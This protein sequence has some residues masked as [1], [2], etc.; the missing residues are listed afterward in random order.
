MKAL[1]KDANAF[2]ETLAAHRLLTT[3]QLRQAAIPAKGLRWAERILSS[4]PKTYSGGGLL[5]RGLA[6]WCPRRDRP[7]ERAWYVTE[8]G[9]RVV[10][11]FVEG[12]RRRQVV[13]AE[14]A[15]GPLQ[16]HSLAV[17]EASLSF[18]RA[19]R[20]R[21]H[22]CSWRHEVPWGGQAGR[23]K[24]APPVISDS[25]VTYRGAGHALDLQHRLVELD[26]AAMTAG[27]LTDKL[28]RYARAALA[29]AAA[30][31]LE[32]E[33][34]VVLD[35][36]DEKAL[37][38]RAQAVIGLCQRDDLLS[39][40]RLPISFVFLVDLIKH[41]PWA[42]VFVRLSEPGKSV[43]WLGEP[44]ARMEVMEAAGK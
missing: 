4:A 16:E 20:S 43:N 2:L 31:T 17:N 26:R 1:H 35:G 34:V 13:T 19:A 6:A 39:R 12:Q 14:Q 41:G 28:H 7:H 24:A 25:V 37:K 10:G 8:Q 30:G 36:L 44:S 29:K 9:W 42:N 15:A 21:G 22:E 3:N 5:Q 11:E 32:E 38:R 23:D 33:V 18:L 40:T 27:E